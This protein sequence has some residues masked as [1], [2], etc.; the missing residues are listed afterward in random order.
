MGT[1]GLL[2]GTAGM[3]GGEWE[4]GEV[5]RE[6]SGPGLLTMGTGALNIT[7][8]LLLVIFSFRMTTAHVIKKQRP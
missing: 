3:G 1:E 8:S 2:S 5:I 6:T 4:A 7:R